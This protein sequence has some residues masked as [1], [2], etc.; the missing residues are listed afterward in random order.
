MNEEEN[1][2]RHIEER[3]EKR[4]F[5]IFSIIGGLAAAVVTLCGVAGTLMIQNFTSSSRAEFEAARKMQETSSEQLSDVQEEAKKIL[6]S[7]V[8]THEEITA[9]RDLSRKV[10]EKMESLAENN[11]NISQKMFTQISKLLEDAESKGIAI[12]KSELSRLEDLV[13]EARN[14]SDA[15]PNAAIQVGVVAY[16]A[17]SVALDE[18]IKILFD[19]LSFTKRGIHKPKNRPSYLSSKNSI[20]YYDDSNIDMAE[21]IKD[22]ASEVFEGEFIAAK[23]QGFGVAD[24][25]RPNTIIVHIVGDQ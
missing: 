10:L 4:F 7:L 2:Y 5:G 15:I 20:L 12:D 8:L 9:S 6:S 18:F 13:A 3:L 22:V 14:L 1:I 21:K 23:G 16:E 25:D 24:S 17:E 19:K 11:A